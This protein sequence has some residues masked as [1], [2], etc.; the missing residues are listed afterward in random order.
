MEQQLQQGTEYVDALIER[1]RACYLTRVPLPTAEAAP[2]NVAD[3]YRL[4]RHMLA[5]GYGQV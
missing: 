4:Y 1:L 5:E 2:L 3:V